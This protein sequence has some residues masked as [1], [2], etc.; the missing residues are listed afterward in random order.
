VLD[1]NEVLASGT[2]TK[3]SL[4]KQALAVRFLANPNGHSFSA[5][6]TGTIVSTQGVGDAENGQPIAP[7]SSYVAAD[8]C[9]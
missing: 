9:R 1:G 5:S 8:P 3:D 2:F 7:T 6:G 4:Q